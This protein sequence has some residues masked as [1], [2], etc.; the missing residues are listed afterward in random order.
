MQWSIPL[1]RFWY[2]E[3]SIDWIARLIFTP[4]Y[5]V[6]VLTQMSWFIT[7]IN[8]AWDSRMSFKSPV[9]WFVLV[10]PWQRCVLLSPYPWFP[11]SHIEVLW[12]DRCMGATLKESLKSQQFN[13]P[14]GRRK[15]RVHG[16]PRRCMSLCCRQAPHWELR[17]KA[18]TLLLT[19]GSWGRA[20]PFIWALI[21]YLSH[22]KIRLSDSFLPS[23][24]IPNQFLPILLRL[25]L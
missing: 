3:D 1:K 9:W 19:Q 4:F 14:I 25:Y 8:T 10:F 2:L 7:W 12:Q 23:P 22:E 15:L 13:L 6:L 17:R 24:L 20:S 11:Q 5:A 18:L 21:P 16:K